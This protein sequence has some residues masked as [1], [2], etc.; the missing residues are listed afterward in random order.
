MA[1]QL[2]FGKSSLN[3]SNFWS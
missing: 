3:Q 2:E 1:N